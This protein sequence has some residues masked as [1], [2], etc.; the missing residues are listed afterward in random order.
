[1][2]L[3]LLLLH[4]VAGAGVLDRVVTV[5]LG[6]CGNEFVWRAVVGCADV[7]CCVVWCCVPLV[8]V[9]RAGVADGMRVTNWEGAGS[10]RDGT[11][12]RLRL[13]SRGVK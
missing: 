2:E 6:Y 3:L 12:C 1:M 5:L 11:E 8:L 10:G 4:A 7:L 13:P 9:V